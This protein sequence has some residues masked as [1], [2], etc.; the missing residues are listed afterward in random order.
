MKF[1]KE[2]GSMCD[3]KCS[4]SYRIFFDSVFLIA[5]GFVKKEFKIK[6][7]FLTWQPW[8]NASYYPHDALRY[9]F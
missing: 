3:V 2:T 5:I 4:G 6:N 8:R 7:Q 9:L 1:R